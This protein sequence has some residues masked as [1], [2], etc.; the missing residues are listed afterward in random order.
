[1]KTKFIRNTGF[2]LTVMVIISCTGS[3]TTESTGQD[4]TLTDS[5]TVSAAAGES[6]FDGKS[7]AYT[8]ST[9]SNNCNF[10][11]ISFTYLYIFLIK[12]MIR[13]QVCNKSVCYL[14]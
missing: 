10:I 9:T 6:L 3:K 1:M 8:I 13:N 14:L 12:Y 2:A 4:S 11:F 5:T 7:L